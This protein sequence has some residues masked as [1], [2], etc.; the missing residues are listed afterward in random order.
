MVQER[1]EYYIRN[2]DLAS[3]LAQVK[4]ELSLVNDERKPERDEVEDTIKR[5]VDEERAIIEDEYRKQY[6]RKFSEQKYQLEDKNKAE[7]DLEK[8]RQEVADNGAVRFRNPEPTRSGLG[9]FAFK[10]D[11]VPFIIRNLIDGNLELIPFF[12]FIFNHQLF[13]FFRAGSW[14]GFYTSSRIASL[15][16]LDVHT[17][18]EPC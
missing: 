18:C 17:P 16:H 14:S 15:H 4:R 12:K 11:D 3:E 6:L 5:R 8:L 10:E 9:M 13:S 7:R 2:R 1:D